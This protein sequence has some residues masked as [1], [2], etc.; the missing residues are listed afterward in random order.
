MSLVLTVRQRDR[1]C[2]FEV[3]ESVDL[4]CHC[5]PA[6]D[7]GPVTLDDAVNLCRE[8]VADGITTVIATPHQLGRYEL[9]NTT[10]DIHKA[11]AALRMALAAAQVP[12]AVLPGADVRIDQRVPELLRAGRLLTLANRGTHLLLELPHDIYIDPLPLIRSLAADGIRVIVS[13]PER[14]RYLN[15][16]PELVLPWLGQGAALQITAGSLLG[17]FGRTAEQTGWGWLD[18]GL[19]EFVASDCHDLHKRPPRISAA[20]EH[21]ANR[22]GSQVAR[23][24]C[25]ENPSKLI[26]ERDSR[27]TLAPRD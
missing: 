26:A 5:L 10:E 19:A 12:L 23:S 25:L 21:I 24:V 1:L 8:L 15:R 18:A 13:H 17:D 11:V 16:N 20:I 2:R 6:L 14:H 27:T 9:G 22:L 7:D 4:H 3:P